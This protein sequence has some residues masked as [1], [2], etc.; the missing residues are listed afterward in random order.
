MKKSGW[1][2]KTKAMRKVGTV[3]HEFKEGTLHSGKSDKIVKNKKQAIAIALSEAGLS[4]KATGGMVLS[5]NEIIKNIDFDDNTDRK[6][7]R[8]DFYFQTEDSQGADMLDYD[9]YI[10]EAP[11]SSRMN[12]EIEWGQNTPEDWENA[13]KI[14]IDAFYEWK[15]N[16]KATGGGVWTKEQRNNVSKLDADFE[17]AVKE[18]G[19]ERNSKD[20]ADFWRSGGF[21]KRMKEIFEKTHTE[22]KKATGGGVGEDKLFDVT[23]FYED[24]E[25]KAD[26]FGIKSKQFWR[27]QYK[28]NAKNEDDAKQETYK[29]F[30][31][32]K[33]N[34]NKIAKNLTAFELKTK[35]AT[36][37]GVGDYKLKD[38][39]DFYYGRKGEEKVVSGAITDILKDGY[40]ISTG[41]TQVMV[42]PNDIVGY[43][44][45]AEP[46]KKRFGIF[47]DGGGVDNKKK[48]MV[49]ESLIDDD[50][51]FRNDSY[52]Y[53]R[54]EE[55]TKI[56][57][58]VGYEKNENVANSLGEIMYF[59]LQKYFLQKYNG[60]TSKSGAKEFEP[61]KDG[62]VEFI[63]YKD[64]E[65]MYEPTY[66]KYYTNDE[67]FDTLKQAQ[68]Y[69]DKGSPMS[70]KTINAYRKGA[71]KDGGAVGNFKMVSFPEDKNYK[72]YVVDEDEDNYL[73][74]QEDMYDKWKNANKIE[75]A[76][77]YSE[78]IPKQEMVETMAKGGGVE[79][80]PQQGTLLTKDK[81]LKLDYKKNG[82][83]FEFVVYEGETNPVANY[84]KTS[85][86]KK[87]KG[88]VTMD[89]NQFM[90]YIYAEGYIDD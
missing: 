88:V 10:I 12:D 89:Y 85:F 74:I 9:G 19:I 13:E 8:Y 36:G 17:K 40:T 28:V 87:E 53:F 62:E 18:K 57:K 41:F 50:I 43:S 48:N 63:E 49:M 32:E 82:N 83:N 79:F 69:I 68:N 39:V 11:A 33:A 1:S 35:K 61:T 21:Q 45:E 59:D 29:Q 22:N 5:N 34:K 84:T 77:Y 51:D 54:D 27:K 60:I 52:P 72:Y 70:A 42:K 44:K 7:G 76:E 37:G 90:N 24:T 58:S 25:A 75:K 26:K 6:H 3:M 73:T 16:K 20:A 56:A 2:S 46:K 14:L 65:I 67:E 15:N 71:F 4:K 80:M 55:L 64:E 38:V 23:V 78:W 30:L 31:S 66:N 86:K 81:K 47:A